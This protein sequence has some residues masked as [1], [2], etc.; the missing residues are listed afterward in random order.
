MIRLTHYQVPVYAGS[1]NGSR[2][3][4][5]AFGDSTLA[6]SCSRHLTLETP[7]QSPDRRGTMALSA[8]IPGGRAMGEDKDERIGPNQPASGLGLLHFE[9]RLTCVPLPIL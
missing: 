1:E 7:D 5:N 8:H 2:V 9:T 6:C 4:S 3:R